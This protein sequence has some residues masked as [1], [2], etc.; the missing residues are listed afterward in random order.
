V[1]AGVM[2]FGAGVL[3]SALA[4]ELADEAVRLGGAVVTAG[5]AVGFLT[6]LAVHLTGG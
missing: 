3:I 1:I 2:A 5:G 4:F 6:A